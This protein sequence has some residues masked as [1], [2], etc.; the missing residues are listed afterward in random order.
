[1]QIV[2]NFHEE[3]FRHSLLQKD[4]FDKQICCSGEYERHKQKMSGKEQKLNLFQGKRVM[5]KI[6]FVYT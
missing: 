3:K 2:R 1:M 5:R 4:C 6:G